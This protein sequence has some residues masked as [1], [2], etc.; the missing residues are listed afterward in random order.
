MY[1]DAVVKMR[2]L[3]RMRLVVVVAVGIAS[4]SPRGVTVEALP[5]IALWAQRPQI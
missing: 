1:P 4:S 3:L 2:V 5:P